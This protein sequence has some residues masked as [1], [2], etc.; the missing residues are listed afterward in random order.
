[1]FW[2]FLTLLVTLSLAANEGQADGPQQYLDPVYSGCHDCITHSCRQV[3]EVKQIKKI[4]YEV[5]EVPFCVKKCPPL[6]TLLHAKGCDCEACAEC[7]LRYKKVL[8][9]REIVCDE[10]CTTKCVVEQ[11]VERVPCA[12]SK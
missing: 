7:C 3:P 4:V 1:M 10:V 12:P 11:H 5:Q 2:R 8:V 9:K 6:W